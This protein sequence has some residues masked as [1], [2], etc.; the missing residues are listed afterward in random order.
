ML[1]GK[2]Q[3]VSVKEKP[4]GLKKIL[5]L[6]KFI[7]ALLI[8]ALRFYLDHDFDLDS[9]TITGIIV[10]PVLYFSIKESKSV[11][12]V[13]LNYDEHIITFH[14][15]QNSINKKLSAKLNGI[16]YS[17]KFEENNNEYVLNIETY[18]GNFFM[19]SF[20]QDGFNRVTLDTLAD[21]LNDCRCKKFGV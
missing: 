15:H 6:S 20:S 8:L 16:K 18:S 17:Y 5:S 9:L 13:E 2:E 10:L 3:F 11:D 4:K 21:R 1:T 7:P 19:I 12:L 14:Y